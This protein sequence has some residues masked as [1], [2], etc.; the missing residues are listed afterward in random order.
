[1]ALK[2]DVIQGL[3]RI[4]AAGKSVEQR[5]EYFGFTFS[6]KIR[7]S[8]QKILTDNPNNL[9]NRFPEKYKN[10]AFVAFH[11]SWNRSP[12]PQKGYLVAFVPFKDGKPSGDWEI[13]A[14]N[15]A[16][17]A[18]FVSPSKAKHRPCGLAQ[19]PDGS[20][21]ISDDSGGIIYR[22]IYTGK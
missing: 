3:T 10:G 13:F 2:G 5:I 17:G 6:K 19:G 14:D 12:E 16:G 8:F 1:M 21:Y 9:K 20:L 18:E 22:I 11:G 7:N 15:F 4:A